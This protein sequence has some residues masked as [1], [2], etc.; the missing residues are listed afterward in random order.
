[1]LIDMDELLKSAEC[2]GN[3]L[4]S[5]CGNFHEALEYVDCMHE[6]AKR[7]KFFEEMI[8]WDLVRLTL[9]DR[10]FK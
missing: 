1:M 4:L 5:I 7:G 3:T 6:D 8:R 9:V 2:A 10:C